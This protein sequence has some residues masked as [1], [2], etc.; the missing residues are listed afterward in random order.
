MIVKKILYNVDI[1]ELYCK[2]VVYGLFD[3]QKVHW[4][5]YAVSTG[6]N[7][8]T[9]SQHVCNS[10]AEVDES[11][12]RRYGKIF[13]YKEDAIKYIDDFKIKWETGSNQTVQEKRDKKL[14][15]ILDEN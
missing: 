11:N 1:T 2:L 8:R 6:T 5:Y 13:E 15:D 3:T 14:G 4:T 10:F 12:I 7:G 9:L